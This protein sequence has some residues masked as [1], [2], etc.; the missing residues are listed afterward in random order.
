MG[1]WVGPEENASRSCPPNP[2]SEETRKSLGALS[3]NDARKRFKDAME[4]AGIDEARLAMSLADALSAYSVKCFYNAKEDKVIESEERIDHAT[5]LKALE[6]SVR[7]FDL[8]PNKKLDVKAEVD[9]NTLSD[10]EIDERIKHLCG[11]LGITG[12]A[13]GEGAKEENK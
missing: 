2:N 11:A 8:E 3:R 6:L 7:Y 5:R 4:L 9:A 10:D 13:E 12:L 1:K